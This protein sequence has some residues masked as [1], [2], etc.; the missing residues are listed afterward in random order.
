MATQYEYRINLDERGEFAA[1]VRHP[2]TEASIFELFTDSTYRLIKDGFMLDRDDIDGLRE[3]LI[4]IGIM[5]ETDNLIN[6]Y[7]D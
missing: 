4:S 6:P 2:D 3:Y 5:Q 1:D 7:E